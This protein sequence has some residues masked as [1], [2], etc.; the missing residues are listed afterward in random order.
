MRHTSAR[1]VVGEGPYREKDRDSSRADRLLEYWRP[2]RPRRLTPRERRVEGAAAAIFV[3]V[4]AA[5]AV[6]SSSEREFDPLLA[7]V[8]IPSYA[9]ASRVRLYLGAGFAMPNQLVLVPMLYLLPPGSVPAVVACALAGTAAI[10]S[11]GG[12]AHPERILTALADAWHVVG[13]ALVFVIAD[14]P[15]PELSS[16]PILAAALVAQCATDL[17]AATVREW[18]GRGIS[19]WAQIR[20]ILTVY[21]I[22]FSLSPIGL[23]IAVAASDHSFAFLLA[24]PLVALLAALAIDRKMRIEEAVGRLDELAEQHA[25]L[26]RAIRRIGESFASKLDRMALVNLVLRTAG[27]ALEAEHGRAT[28]ASGTV[29]WAADPALAMPEA[30]L[31]AAEGAA[32]R[33]GRLRTVRDGDHAAMAQPVI[34]DE[35]ADGDVLAIARRG[36]PFTTAEEGLF[37]YLAQQAAVAI[38]NVALHDQLQRQAT[39]DELTGLANHRRFQDALAFEFKRMR[40]SGRPL[41]LVLFDL[42][43]FK[44]VNDTYGHQQGDRVLQAV[45]R[46]MRD[47]CRSTDEPAR[48]GGEELALILPETDLDGGFTL[49]EAIRC[50]V[51]DLEIP[52][53][54]GTPLRVTV[55]AG[56]SALDAATADPAA[57]IQAS[58]V[59]LYQAK[60]AGRNRTVRGR[61]DGARHPR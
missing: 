22:D 4:A 61:T 58:D 12:R 11:L 16:W 17:I 13:G 3:V 36:R 23:A 52:L 8:L 25:R 9:F 53:G 31:A 37:G 28:S 41:A 55:S 19:P 47:A 46:V 51:E 50:G 18:L 24:V 49:A 21:A 38:E 35:H 32:R 59:A 29:E 54:D 27:E 42:D 43:N 40:R 30:A 57:L 45:A 33:E 56:V 60:R 10:D 39:V 26:D 5:M 6:L 34:A 7:L 44:R 48:Y 20:V 1:S 15:D 2:Y 14:A